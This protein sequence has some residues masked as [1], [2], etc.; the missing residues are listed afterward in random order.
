MTV[1]ILFTPRTP[2]HIPKSEK[3]A[4][5]SAQDKEL[6]GVKSNVSQVFDRF[7]YNVNVC[8][9]IEE[10]AEK[11]VAVDIFPPSFSRE[12]EEWSRLKKMQCL[13]SS[14]YDVQ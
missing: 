1:L 2:L 11:E 4:M 12:R 13:C 7:A 6:R 14:L 10:C 9:C 3:F 8:R 5:E